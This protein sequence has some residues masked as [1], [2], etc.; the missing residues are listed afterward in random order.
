[1][2]CAAFFIPAYAAESTEDNTDIEDIVIIPDTVITLTGET[3]PTVIIPPLP[4]NRPEPQE[5]EAETPEINNTGVFTTPHGAGTL[6]EDVTD[7][8]VNR[9]FITIQSRGGK[10]FYI[11]IDNDR[12]KQNVYFLNAVDD[13]DLLTFSDDFPDGVLEAYEELKEEALNAVNGEDTDGTET[14]PADPV[15]PE[16]TEEN[17]EPVNLN[18]IYIIGGV[19]ALFLV[20]LIYFKVIKPKKNGGKPK[21]NVRDVDEDEDE[22]ED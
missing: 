21:N 4:S 6:L 20:G 12:D 19:G 22:S 13:F 14:K 15:N 17:G 9:Q 8:E 16:N 7:N 3:P 1:M 5:P 18:Q 10:V 2:L 11:I